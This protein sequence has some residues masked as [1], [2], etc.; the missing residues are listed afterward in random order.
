MAACMDCRCVLPMRCRPTW[1]ELAVLFEGSTASG[2]ERAYKKAV[3][4]LT[5][6]LIEDSLFHTIV[7]KRKCQKK[8][9]EKISA[10]TYLY[11][12]DC[13]GEWDEIQF[14]FENRTAQIIRL[15]D[16][17]KMVSQPFAKYSIY[18]LL[19]CQNETLPKETVILFEM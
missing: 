9:K 19:N 14:D 11:Q 15:A 12:A 18:Y 6:L 2:A 7:L 3:Q 1:E 8:R 17:D 5:Q 16:W 10:A 4:K 13:D